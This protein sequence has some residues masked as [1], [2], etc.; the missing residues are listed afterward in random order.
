M[1]VVY[2]G[3]D[4]VEWEDWGAGAQYARIDAQAMFTFRMLEAGA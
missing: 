2:I 3:N 1:A 4:G